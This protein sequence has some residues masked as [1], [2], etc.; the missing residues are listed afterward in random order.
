MV[1]GVERATVREEG[2]EGDRKEPQQEEPIPSE[3]SS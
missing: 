1:W 2:I 3:R